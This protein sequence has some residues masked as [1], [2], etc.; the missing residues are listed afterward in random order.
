MRT[1]LHLSGL[2]ARALLAVSELLAFFDE[3]NNSS[4][5]GSACGMDLETP[6]STSRVGRE[7]GCDPT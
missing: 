1:A 2:A 3:S 5:V 4:L 7:G 6:L